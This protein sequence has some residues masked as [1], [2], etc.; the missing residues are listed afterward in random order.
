MVLRVVFLRFGC[1]SS[2]SPL[3]CFVITFC[4]VYSVFFFSR[5][6]LYLAH[7]ADYRYLY[8]AR[9]TAYIEEI[10]PSLFKHGNLST[11]NKILCKRGEAISPLFQNIFIISLDQITNSFGNCGCSIYFCLNSA[12]LLCR[13]T[14][15]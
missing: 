6:K 5:K 2:L 3:L 13:G 1:R 12:N 9:I 8:F 4:F 11:G 7:T 14:D 10:I 15:I